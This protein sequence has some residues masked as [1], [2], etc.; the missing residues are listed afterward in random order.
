MVAA[1]GSSG[2]LALASY[3]L[4]ALGSYGL[5][6]LGSYGLLALGSYGL[7]ALASYGLPALLACSASLQ[8]LL[9]VLPYIACFASLFGV[10]APVSLFLCER[11]KST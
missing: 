1:L 4:L 10:H 6:A 11:I 7:L 9:A 8:C 2:L 3:G 5:L